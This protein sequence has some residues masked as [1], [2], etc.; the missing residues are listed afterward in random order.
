MSVI[1][2]LIACSILVAAGFLAA[3]L[4]AVRTGQY[5]DKHTPSMRILFDDAAV[6]PARTADEPK[7]RGADGGGAEGSTTTGGTTHGA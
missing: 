5:D 4:W 3:F 6:K 7:E 1:A 2:F